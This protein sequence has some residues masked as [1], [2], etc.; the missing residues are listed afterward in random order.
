MHDADTPITLNTVRR[1]AFVA[2]C[3]VNQN[4]KVQEFARAA[5]VVPGVIER[6]RAHGYRLQQLPCPEMAFAGINRWWQEREST[7]RRITVG[8]AKSWPRT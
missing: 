8:T 7:T 4:A 5:G 3:L 6:L 1:V 2:H